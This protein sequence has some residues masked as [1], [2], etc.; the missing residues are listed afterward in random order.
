[1]ELNLQST[2][3]QLHIPAYGNDSSLPDKD[4]PVRDLRTQDASLCLCLVGATF[5]NMKDLVQTHF[6][7]LHPAMV[8]NIFTSDALVICLISANNLS[9][10]TKYPVPV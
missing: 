8:I 3:H 6:I 4:W 10:G 7:S 1:M 2:H 9:A 5:S